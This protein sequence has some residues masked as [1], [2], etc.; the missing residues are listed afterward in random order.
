MPL[1]LFPE[2][3]LQMWTTGHKLA[4][5]V[6]LVGIEQTLLRRVESAYLSW[7]FGRR[8]PEK[9]LNLLIAIRNID[10]LKDQ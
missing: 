5:W 4:P 1:L 2:L 7:W 6:R 9:N 3:T 8:V 10:A